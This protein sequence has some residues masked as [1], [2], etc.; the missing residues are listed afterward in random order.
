MGLHKIIQKISTAVIFITKPFRYWLDSETYKRSESKMKL[1]S[2]RNIYEGETVLV[3]GNGPSLLNTPL[4]K[5]S[6]FPSIGMNKI[7]M[8]YD[9]TSWR[10]SVI[11][12]SNNLVVKQHSSAYEEADT[13]LFLSWKA[14]KFLS[15]ALRSKVNFFLTKSD[16]SFS[17]DFSEGVGASGTVTYAA[18]QLAFYMGAQRVILFGVDHNFKYEGSPHEVAKMKEVDSNHFDPNYFAKGQYWGIPNLDASEKG[19]EAARRIFEAHGR[20]ILDATVG[21]KLQVFKKINLDE[22]LDICAAGAKK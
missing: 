19:Y 2:Y 9:K 21:G 17:K 7:D 20:S 14:R 11:I 1:E 3:V 22:A 18:L 10:P 6:S 15:E 8:L 16:S 12:S 13:P 5:F 4:E